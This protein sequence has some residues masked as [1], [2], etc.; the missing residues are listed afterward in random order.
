MDRGRDRRGFDDRD[1]GYGA[2]VIAPLPHDEVAHR[3]AEAI[4][5]E[6]EDLMTEHARGRHLDVGQEVPQYEVVATIVATE[7]GP[8]HLLMVLV[9]LV[10]PPTAASPDHLSELVH[11]QGHRCHREEIE[12]EIILH[13]ETTDAHPLPNQG[14]LQ[15]TVTATTMAQGAHTNRSRTPPPRVSAHTSRGASPDSRHSG[16]GS[17]HPDRMDRVER[18]PDRPRR[19][20]SPPFRSP[21]EP[22]SDHRSSGY[23][24]RDRSPPPRRAY[25]PPA[26]SPPRQ[27]ASWRERERERTPPLARDRDRDRDRAPP[28]RARESPREDATPS[29][30]S[31][32]Q[33]STPRFQNGDSRAPPTGPRERYNSDYNRDAPP[34]GPPTGP[35]MINHSRGS[36]LSAPTRP[37]RD[38][39]FRGGRGR[40]HFS[41]PP[42]PRTSTYDRDP[43][44]PPTGPRNSISH[45][46][47]HSPPARFDSGPPS[48]SRYD[49]DATRYPSGPRY[50]SSPRGGHPSYDHA[51]LPTRGSRDYDFPP[52][53]GRGAHGPPFRSNNST[54][55]TYPR[56]QRFNHPHPSSN[57]NTS[58]ASNAVSVH[59]ASVAALAESGAG[60]KFPSGLEPGQEKRL[61]QLEDEKRK[62]EE[63][64]GVKEE[65]KRHALREWDRVDREAKREAFKGALA[66]EHLAKLSGEVGGAAY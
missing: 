53:S 41:G 39:G 24:S 3:T 56:T 16:S 61:A 46:Q 25:S 5:Q 12:T 63:Q 59:L 34:S 65:R 47:A 14:G 44:A 52:T 29:S 64:I 42:T 19:G 27:E 43:G 60:K 17:M 66:D 33:M 54:S 26:R 37:S 18:V 15:R 40:G 38:P 55:T 45:A 2:F 22:I 35:S 57:N 6:E 1:A 50:P 62:L 31:N 21:R 58:H 4:L 11:G 36:I 49:S 13:L 10:H 51:P 9:D 7:E 30:W 8:A 20:A 23:H 48:A 28:P 32:E